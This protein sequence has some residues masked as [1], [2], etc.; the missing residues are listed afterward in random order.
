VQ[1]SPDGRWV[2]YHAWDSSALEV[3]VARFPSFADAQQVS[4]S[5]GGVQPIWAHD[6]NRLFYLAF[7][8]TMMAVDLRR[9]GERLT[10][11]APRALFATRLTNPSSWVSEYDVAKDGRFL[12]IEREPGPYTLTMLMNW[13]PAGP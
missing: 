9:G 5:R 7:D 2:A 11:D 12:I 4:A 3:H 6:G 1:V 13:A 10:A 8:G